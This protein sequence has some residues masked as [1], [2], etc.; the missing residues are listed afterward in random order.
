ML[1][2]PAPKSAA[3]RPAPIPE[4]PP[5]GSL[6]SGGMFMNMSPNFLGASP[7]GKSMDMVDICT[8]LLQSGGQGTWQGHGGHLLAAAAVMWA[9]SSWGGGARVGI[10]GARGRRN[11]L[12][13]CAAR[14]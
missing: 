3:A 5:A 9:W 8:Q 13:G 6:G 14:G 2:L 1:T 11:W 4:W 7:L 10:G 12:A